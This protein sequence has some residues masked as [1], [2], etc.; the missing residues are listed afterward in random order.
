MPNLT[1]NNNTYA[2]PDP[3]SEQGWGPDA[4]GWAEDVTEALESLAGTGSINE[5]Q[6]LIEL[7]ATNQEIP[8]LL[9][10]SSIVQ[11]A[12]VFYRIYRETSDEKLAESGTLEVVHDPATSQ[13]IMTRK[14]TNNESVRVSLDITGNA[15]GQVI[16]S[17]TA[18][19]G[20]DYTGYIKFKT[21][22]IL[23]TI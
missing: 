16:Y 20:T 9:F 10:N 4:T 12:E 1:V 17:S 11:S 2:Y 5:T 18:L 14:F 6:A 3:G 19:T 22:T 13:W 15:T 7:T 21:I 8:G 23:Q